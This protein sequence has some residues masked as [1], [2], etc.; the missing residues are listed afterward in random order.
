MK[1]EPTGLLMDWIGLTG[2]KKEELRMIIN[3]AF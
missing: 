3:K 1:V 2:F